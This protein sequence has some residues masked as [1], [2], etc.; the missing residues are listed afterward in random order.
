MSSGCVCVDCGKVFNNARSFSIHVPHHKVEETKCPECPKEFTNKKAVNGHIWT[1]HKGHHQCT[2]SYLFH[3][4]NA[5]PN[6]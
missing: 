4:N 6:V 2:Q 1:K 5:S 3:V